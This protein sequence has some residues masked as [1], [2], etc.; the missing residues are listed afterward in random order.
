MVLTGG[1]AMVI[2]PQ[3]AS[4]GFVAPPLL[5]GGM[6]R[7]K[8]QNALWVQAFKA[9]TK[10]GQMISGGSTAQ[11]IAKEINQLFRGLVRQNPITQEA[12]DTLK[13][14]LKPELMKGALC[15]AM[16]KL[17]KTVNP[18]MHGQISGMSKQPNYDLKNHFNAPKWINQTKEGASPSLTEIADFYFTDDSN[19]TI[20]QQLDSITP[21]EVKKTENKVIVT[22]TLGEEAN[23]KAAQE[24]L[25]QVLKGAVQFIYV[26]RDLKTI[27]KEISNKIDA[28]IKD[29]HGVNMAMINQKIDAIQFEM[30]VIKAANPAG[31]KNT[32]SKKNFKSTTQGYRFQVLQDRLN[33]LREL[34][35]N[36]E[37][38]TQKLKDA[39]NQ[40]R[41]LFELLKI[42]IDNPQ[43]GLED[44][45]WAQLLHQNMGKINEQ[46]ISYLANQYDE[47]WGN[48]ATEL[49]GSVS[50][51]PG[52]I[53]DQI[54]TK[55]K[56]D[57]VA[58]S[59]QAR[60][61][62]WGLDVSLIGVQDE[63]RVPETAFLLWGRHAGVDKKTI[64]NLWGKLEEKTPQNLVRSLGVNYAKHPQKTDAM[65]VK[66]KDLNGQLE[67]IKSPAADIPHI[68]TTGDKNNLAQEN[69]IRDFGI[70]VAKG[71]ISKKVREVIINRS[72]R[73][74]LLKKQFTFKSNMTLQECFAPFVR[75]GHDGQPEVK[76][77]L[78]KGPKKQLE[79]LN[80]TMKAAIEKLMRGETIEG[81]LTKLNEAFN[82]ACDDSAI[83]PHVIDIEN[84]KI[85]YLE[86]LNAM[87]KAN[88][89][90]LAKSIQSTAA[91]TI[92][93]DSGAE[94]RGV[95]LKDKT[96]E[97]G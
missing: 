91:A 63:Y 51:T 76:E 27:Q 54:N 32:E 45:V 10:I 19:K 66:L 11:Q 41:K 22:L 59:F 34:K 61:Q 86:Q 82:K 53:E 73:T 96:K 69:K 55:L 43:D 38:N 71:K 75:P 48:I 1:N 87:V 78:F 36:I 37:G 56:K 81:E 6:K 49:A 17:L 77:I 20:R 29:G 46:L 21:A 35:E 14:Q 89:T 62:D 3:R 12:V 13:A 64:M 90:Q 2:N 39:V 67:K 31:F 79:N 40:P 94:I 68:K 8:P 93:L 60:F 23:Y 97:P 4:P 74:D 18:V 50:I 26:P 52:S 28:L 24:F 44:E 85:H 30:D 65:N 25:E 33:G 70:K 42:S 84:M 95:A 57:K 80:S 47:V 5:N 9:Q 7:G 72:N 15:P 16:V 88:D 92:T 83:S 58:D